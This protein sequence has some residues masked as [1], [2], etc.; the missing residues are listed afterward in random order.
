MK[1]Q[2]RTLHDLSP[3]MWFLQ[4]PGSSF[5]GSI[6]PCLTQPIG[7]HTW[8]AGS[9]KASS[10]IRVG[11]QS[12]GYKSPGQLNDQREL[13]I[14]VLALR[15]QKACCFSSR[16]CKAVNRLKVKDPNPC[17]GYEGCYCH[18]CKSLGKALGNKTWSTS[19]KSR[20]LLEAEP[21][22]LSSSCSTSCLGVMMQSFPTLPSFLLQR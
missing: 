18:Q 6:V 15:Q 16:P 7:Q 17:K 20:L 8:D 2:K 19:C 5:T 12:S 9:G 14:M 10:A 1:A 4:T 11:T 3:F 21:F 13:Q 22:V